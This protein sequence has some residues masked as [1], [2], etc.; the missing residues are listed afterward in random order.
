MVEESLQTALDALLQ[1]QPQ[2][3]AGIA[4]EDGLPVLVARSGASVVLE[5]LEA[6]SEAECR[7]HALQM[8]ELPFILSDPPLLR[9]VL[10]RF[11]THRRW[12]LLVAHHLILDGGSAPR[13]LELWLSLALE[14]RGDNPVISS[15]LPE[16]ERPARPVGAYWKGRLS[17]YPVELASDFPRDSKP[18]SRSAHYSVQLE[19]IHAWRALAARHRASLFMV[20]VTAF[21]AWLKVMTA[22]E[23]LQ[24]AVPWAPHSHRQIGS[25]ADLLILRAEVSLEQSFGDVLESVR[26][27]CLESYRQAVPFDELVAALTPPR[28]PNRSPFFN[29]MLAY[30][31]GTTPNRQPEGLEIVELLPVYEP[32]YADVTLR[33]TPTGDARWIYRADLFRPETVVAWA[34]DWKRCCSRWLAHPDEPLVVSPADSPIRETV[35]GRF[36]RFGSSE[37]T[38]LVFHNQ[39]LTFRQLK[40][41]A[42]ELGKQLA[43]LGVGRGHKV[44]LLLERSLR[45][46]MAMLAVLGLGAAYVPLDPLSPPHRV[47]F[48]LQDCGA[49]AVVEEDGARRLETA[50]SRESSDVACIMYTSGSSDRPKGVSIP[51]SGI[52]R[53]V[54]DTD[55]LAFGPQEVGA[56]LGPLDF[57]WSTF[58]IWSCL[59]NGSTLVVLPPGPPD[60]VEL[61]RALRHH[62]VTTLD[63]STGMFHWMVDH[64]LHELHGIRQL[65]VAGDVMA[66][67]CARRFLEVHPDCALFNVYGPTEDSAFS[68]FHRVRERDLD[69]PIPIG[70]SLP[71]KEALVLDALLQPVPPGQPGELCLA[72]DG[73]AVG[74]LHQSEQTRERFPAHPFRAGER[75]YRTGDLTARSKDGILYFLG[76]MDRQ[77][78]VRGNRLE[79]REIEAC[80]ESHPLV[81]RAAVVVEPASRSRSG[82]PR[83]RALVVAVTTAMDLAQELESYLQSRLPEFM[84]PSQVEVVSSLPVDNRGKLRLPPSPA[85]ATTSADLPVIQE[86]WESV[87]GCQECSLDDNFFE[88]GGHSLQAARLAVQLERRLARRLPL[89]LVFRAPTLRALDALLARDRGQ[90][91]PESCLV[92]IQDGVGTP[93]ICFHP[94]GGNCLCY[95]QLA[96]LLPGVRVLGVE[97]REIEQA[98]SLEEVCAVYADAIRRRLPAGPY[99]LLGLSLGGLLAYEVARQLGQVE[100]IILIDT[101]APGYP[102]YWPGSRNRFVAR[103]L[104]IALLALRVHF[105]ARLVARLPWK[106][107]FPYVARHLRRSRPAGPVLPL[108]RKVIELSKAYLARPA[109][110]PLL[111]MQAC[112]QPLEAVR[113][114]SNGWKD[115]ALGS[116]RVVQIPGFHGTMLLDKPQVD[117]VAALL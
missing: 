39:T 82:S 89:A 61:G 97:A 22:S 107:R 74:Y 55:Y 70:K 49:I 106:A 20:C 13:F 79:P 48:L 111:L 56:H 44:A 34:Q 8:T 93:L 100:E 51:H 64:H 110:H 103:A 36:Q 59:L 112:H 98:Q 114:P 21:L 7:A 23:E 33:I 84:L 99:R 62:G 87:L 85:R 115:L 68:C 90:G 32:A 101:Y 2:L 92:Q 116:L 113:H 27:H 46:P 38:A 26:S 81:S 63:L 28:S 9:A 15:P 47:R 19:D 109:H 78:K 35:A 69:G 72:G 91:V 42:D 5:T 53:L 88:L 11:G 75:I 66:P 24:I 96:R 67:D 94:A 1:T 4:E 105:H 43:Q 95:G 52:L 45:A 18:E 10:Y 71:G 58:E 6:K 57:D 108:A 102:R 86:V 16:T 76:R 54:C 104:T 60:P 17:A 3:C 117:A 37:K 65:I 31:N 12:L 50:P 80:L 29:L 77:L 14:A 83:L 73:L 30:E 40:E 41:Q 25:F